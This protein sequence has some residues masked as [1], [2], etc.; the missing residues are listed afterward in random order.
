[1]GGEWRFE[2]R[3]SC[4][5]R[6]IANARVAG[7]W[8]VTS[9]FRQRDQEGALTGDRPVLVL[10][11]DHCGGYCFLF[12]RSTAVHYCSIIAPPLHIPGAVLAVEPKG[13]RRGCHCV[14]VINVAPHSPLEK[15]G[16]RRPER[17]TGRHH[18]SI[19]EYVF[20]NVFGPFHFFIVLFFIAP[21][22]SFKPLESSR[23]SHKTNQH[24]IPTRTART[25][26]TAVGRTSFFVA[27]L[28][29]V[30]VSKAHAD[31]TDTRYY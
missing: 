23:S 16:S 3:I 4:G 14:R 30:A 13:G 25:A 20:F 6:P 15:P 11:L 9:V 12:S 27:A 19:N 31:C 29:L 1:M 17:P 22:A 10:L 26:A 21:C 24:N 2:T 7:R 8:E 5:C 18:E 28:T